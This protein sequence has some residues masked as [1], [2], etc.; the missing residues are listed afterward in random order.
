MA[1]VPA[2]GRFAT[3]ETIRESG[4]ASSFCIQED[5]DQ[6]LDRQF[7]SGSRPR[8]S[9]CTP[10]CAAH[11]VRRGSRGSSSRGAFWVERE[12]RDCTGSPWLHT[13]LRR[14]GSESR[15]SRKCL[16][17]EIEGIL[18]GRLECPLGS[19]RW[20]SF[21][22]GPTLGSVWFLSVENESVAGC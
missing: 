3:D 8:N 21:V 7:R 20:F 10:H 11:Q 15:T 9:T 17:S 22:V 13:R 18:E 4:P 14:L 2:S 6:F 12:R 19:L 5:R 16:E 1:A